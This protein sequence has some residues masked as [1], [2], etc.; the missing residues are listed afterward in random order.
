MELLIAP[1]TV[2]ESARDV[3]PTTGTPGWATDG[4]AAAGIPATGDLACHYN[5]MMAEIIQPILDAGLTLDRTNWGQLSA[6]IKKLIQDAAAGAPS[7]ETA[8]YDTIV[9]GGVRIL[10]FTTTAYDGQTI[11]FPIAFSA[12]PSCVDITSSESQEG[13]KSSVIANE[14]EGYRT[15]TG[16]KPHLAMISGDNDEAITEATPVTISVLAI[17]PA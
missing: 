13:S 8:A 6:A 14:F 15:A 4:N 12:V 16:F 1:N 10:S 2:A 17:G 11:N 3:M 5:M 7:G 9:V